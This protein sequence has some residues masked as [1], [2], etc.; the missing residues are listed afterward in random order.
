[1]RCK[2]CLEKDTELITSNKKT[3]Y[4]CKNCDYIFIDSRYILSQTEEKAC[5]SNHQNSIQNR[6]YV[7]MFD[8]FLN[9]IFSHITK[10]PGKVLDFG[11]GPGPVLY[12]LLIKQGFHADRYDPYFYDDKK[13]LQ[14]SYDLIVATEVFEHLSDP[15]K[16]FK[17]LKDIT[18]TGG[19]IALMTSFHPKDSKKFNSWYYTLDSTHIG[20]FT[21][22]T[23]IYLAK[24][25]LLKVVY[26][27]NSKVVLFQKI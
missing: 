21:D 10:K 1:M 26:S 12:Q 18:A 27:D 6:G 11:C 15:L 25:L 23:F 5:Y 16:V 3:Y 4:H 17:Q 24:E 2:L 13:V 14:K 20:F 7:A 8:T 19:Y 9:K 22:K